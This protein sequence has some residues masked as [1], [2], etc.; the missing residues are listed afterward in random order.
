MRV[1]IL[2]LL[3]LTLAVV[4][5]CAPALAGIGSDDRAPV[6]TGI[7]T[8]APQ[9]LP[10]ETPPSG[11]ASQFR[12]DFS[13][14][15]VPYAEILSGGPP[16]D[17]IPAIDRP[18]YVSIERADEW[19]KPREPVILLE[20]DGVARAYPLQILMWHE[21]VNDTLASVPV[22]VTFCPLCN[23]AIAFE[24]RVG[25]NRVTTFGTTGLL[26]FSNLIMYDRLTE[27]WWQQATGEGIAGEHAGDRLRFLPATI[28]AWEAFKQA[29]PEADVLSRETGFPRSYG[30][31]PYAGYDDVDESPFL[32]QGPETPGQLP[33]MARVLTV[34]LNG[35]AVAYPFTELGKV[36]MVNDVVG[37]A[38]VVVFWEAGT[39]SALDSGVIAQGRD[40]GTADTYSRELEGRTLTFY[41]DGERFIDEQT[42]S[43]WTLLGQAVAGPLAGK[44]LS[45]VVNVNHFW[46]SWAAF[47]PETRIFQ[48]EEASPVAV[49]PSSAP[50]AVEIDVTYDFTIR[51]YQGETELGAQELKF[52]EVFAPGKPVILNLWA[53]LCPTCRFELP[54]LQAAYQEH[55]ERILFVGIDI[56]PFTGLGL[57]ADG[58][59]LL[60]DLMVSFPAGST[61]ES[62]IMREYKVLGVPETLFFSADGKLVDRFSGLLN[63]KRLEQNIQALLTNWSFLLD[64]AEQF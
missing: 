43:E 38:P 22:A 52:S 20:I 46:F 64:C 50:A 42:G 62:A 35:E 33:A 32:F 8:T 29:H 3:G 36:R 54:V 26:R 58:R 40:V 57:E 17:G 31:N 27:T 56:G 59:A 61:P 39:A 48:S 49:D 14:H 19:L 16:K 6:E 11:A 53:G 51:L 7:P 9:F 41:Y 1:R 12:T 37:D 10:E 15:T 47:R 5:A 28:V 30:V 23:T 55:G 21:I 13:R 18:S 2:S 25:D 63:E 45:P 4:T 34:E 60:A 24:R 44:R